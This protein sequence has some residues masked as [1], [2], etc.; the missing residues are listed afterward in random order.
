MCSNREYR[1]YMPSRTSCSMAV[2]WDA[3]LVWPRSL[4][5]IARDA[6][7][8]LAAAFDA[9]NLDLAAELIWTWPMLRL[10]WSPVAT[11]GFG[12]LAAAQDLHGFLPGPG[13]SAGDYERLP[14]DLRDEYVLRTSYHTT[15]VMGFVCGAALRAA[16]APPTLIEP[17]AEE[18]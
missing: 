1:I 6:E 13:Y 12:I 9:D 3:G 17:A 15:L 11:F 4:E 16:L 5:D 18:D 2:I 8:A 10:Q 7:A 14:S